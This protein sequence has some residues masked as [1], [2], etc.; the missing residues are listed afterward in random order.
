M[1][2]V[3]LTPTVWMYGRNQQHSIVINFSSIKINEF[4]G[5]RKIKIGARRAIY[6]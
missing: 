1:V 3:C 2:Y 6:F 4:G 5:K